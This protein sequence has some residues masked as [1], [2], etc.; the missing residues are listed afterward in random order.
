M[1][2]L[3]FLKEFSATITVVVGMISGA[4]VWLM[5]KR[6]VNLEASTSMLEQQRLNMDQLL[7]QNRE[8]ADDL[9]K[10]R[11]EMAEV[12]EECDKLRSE[13]SAM[14]TWFG[15]RVQFCEG[16]GLVD[17]AEKLFGLQRRKGDRDRIVRMH[18]GDE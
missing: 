13:I 5:S 14:R 6:K 16:C 4:I 3:D 7:K 9:A 15:M 1:E 12:H 8:L 18:K 11:R 2:E 17:G 10:L